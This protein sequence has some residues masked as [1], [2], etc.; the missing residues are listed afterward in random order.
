MCGGRGGEGWTLN[1]M[2]AN[3]RETFP[4]RAAHGARR[5]D[6]NLVTVAIGIRAAV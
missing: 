3:G 2:R 4:P 1:D 6:I 5:C